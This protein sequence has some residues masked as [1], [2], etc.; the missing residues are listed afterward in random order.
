MNVPQYMLFQDSGVLHISNDDLHSILKNKLELQKLQH[1]TYNTSELHKF[2]AVV[3]VNSSRVSRELFCQFRRLMAGNV[4][5][6][7]Q[8]IA[9]H[10]VRSVKSGCARYENFL[11]LPY[12]R[13]NF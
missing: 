6:R 2:L 9:S 11:C 12:P 4:S 3:E 5:I 7:K 1:Q 10:I 8:H 13:R